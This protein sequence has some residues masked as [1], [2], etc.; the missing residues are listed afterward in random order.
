M[1]IDIVEKC[2]AICGLPEDSADLEKFAMLIVAECVYAC[3][4]DRLGKTAGVEELIANHFGI[5][6]ER[7]F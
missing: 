7:L 3:A 6:N 4:T 2:A 1:S 5:S